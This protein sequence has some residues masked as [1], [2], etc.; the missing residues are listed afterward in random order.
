V[1]DSTGLK[2]IYDVDVR[3]TPIEPNTL[4]GAGEPVPVTSEPSGLFRAIQEQ[5]GLKLESRR[6]PV[7][8]LVVE[9]V[10][11]VPTAN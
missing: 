5:L 1:L 11:R 2:A 7:K 10:E 3:W 4:A 9:N 6:A 8:V